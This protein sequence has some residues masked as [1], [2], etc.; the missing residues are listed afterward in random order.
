MSNEKR[1][2]AEREERR[3]RVQGDGAYWLSRDRWTPGETQVP[4]SITWAEHLE[5]WVLYDAKHHA[6]QSAER[7]AERGGFS[8]WECA[9]LLG[10]E[11]RTWLPEDSRLAERSKR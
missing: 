6:R 4:G 11:L 1:M 9:D 2:T 10:H 5:V 7:I 8:Y 3:T